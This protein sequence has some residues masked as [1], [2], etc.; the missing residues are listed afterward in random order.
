MKEAGSAKR[1]AFMGI[2]GLPPD[3][4]GAGGGDRAID[5]QATRLAARGHEV[6]VYCRWNYLRHPPANYKGVRLRS[7]PTLTGA[8]LE[9]LSHTFLSTLHTLF[10]NSADIVCF[11]GMGNALFIPLLKIGGKRSV[12]FM[13]GIDW[14]RPKWGPVAR[15]LLKMGAASAYHWGDAVTVDNRISQERFV[16][17]YGREPKFISL[18]SDIWEPPGDDLVRALGLTPNNY[19]LF[20]G[21]LRPDKGVHLLIDAY[22]ELDT[23]VPL[24][25]VGDTFDNPTYKQT[26]IDSAGENVHFLG[27]RYGLEAQQLF[28]NCLIYVQPS[29]MEGNSPAL[30]SAMSCGRC[31]VVN[32]IDQ[33][34]ET[35]GEAGVAF[36]A[37]DVADL[38]KTL[39]ALLQNPAEIDKF[40]ALALQRIK[41]VYDWERVVDQ[42]EDVLSPL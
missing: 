34:R 31:V 33:N 37:G 1:I 26:L 18:G 14:E 21:M 11:Q 20:V 10:T 28:A 22:N 24:V 23:D 25:I 4:P 12:V 39:S 13:D 38:Q 2:R 9:T 27:Y 29:I 32:G 3:L 17:I 7:L 35:I 8:G 5:A 16:E 36:E 30:M 40:G 15:M 42:L 41:D 6:T 19:I